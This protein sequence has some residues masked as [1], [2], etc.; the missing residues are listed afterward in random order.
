MH[1]ATFP[2]IL[3]KFSIYFVLYFEL[4]FRY[5]GKCIWL[6]LKQ[7]FLHIF[8]IFSSRLAHDKEKLWKHLRILKWKKGK[9][10]EK[11]ANRETFVSIKTATGKKKYTKVGKKICF[12]MNLWMT[13][14]SWKKHILKTQEES[15]FNWRN[16]KNTKNEKKKK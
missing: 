3:I 15:L 10:E 4:M 7:F 1:I 8:Y 12:K 2:V 6:Y 16:K 14:M 13:D 9:I 11:N 5:L